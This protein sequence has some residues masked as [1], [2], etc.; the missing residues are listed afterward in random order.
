M[1]ICANCYKK[2]SHQMFRP[3]DYEYSK[4]RKAFISACCDAPTVQIDGRQYERTV[5]ELRERKRLEQWGA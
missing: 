5:R 1:R 2:L 4:A 3:Y